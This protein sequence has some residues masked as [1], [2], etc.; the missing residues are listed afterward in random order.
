MPTYPYTGT[1]EKRLL[2]DTEYC[3]ARAEQLEHEERLEAD[4]VQLG[5]AFIRDSGIE[6]ALTKLSRYETS[7]Q[8]NFL[9]VFHELQRLQAG[10]VLILDP[11]RSAVH[12]GLTFESCYLR[13][14]MIDDAIGL[15][16]REL[17]YVAV[18][19][20]EFNLEGLSQ[21]PCRL[22]QDRH[23]YAKYA[24]IILLTFLKDLVM[25]PLRAA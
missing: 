6:N 13:L 2:T 21:I 4:S 12:L 3:R 22:L 1:F 10:R 7:L 9:R 23:E 14:Q 24:A 25:A 20:N 8:R 11:P 15:F 17:S 16:V 19:A 5:A 18:P